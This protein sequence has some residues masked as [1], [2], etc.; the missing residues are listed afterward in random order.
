MSIDTVLSLEH[1]RN[2]YLHLE[3]VLSGRAASK[4]GSGARSLFLCKCD[5]RQLTART[6]YGAK[7]KLKM[8]DV[9]LHRVFGIDGTSIDFTVDQKTGHLI[10]AGRDYGPWGK[11]ESKKKSKKKVVELDLTLEQL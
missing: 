10:V 5:G 7:V 2:T 9:R 1:L 4:L 6:S 11:Y 3:V 8:S